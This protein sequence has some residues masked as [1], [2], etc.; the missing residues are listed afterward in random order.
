[1]KRFSIRVDEQLLAQIDEIA[2]KEGVTRSALTRRLFEAELR[3]VEISKLRRVEIAELERRDREGYLK[4]PITAAEFEWGN[5]F[6]P[7]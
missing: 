3:R 5:Q 6:G 2:A 1:M 7:E 4:E